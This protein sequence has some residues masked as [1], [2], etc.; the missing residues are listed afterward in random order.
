MGQD[1]GQGPAQ[2]PVR[3]RLPKPT[4]ASP[5]RPFSSSRDFPTPTSADGWLSLLKAPDVTG[6]RVALDKVGDRDKA[7]V[8]EALME[9]L[10][11][12]ERSLRDVAL[13]RLT[14]LEAGRKAL[15]RQLLETDSVDRAWSLARAQ[16][17]F[18]KTYPAAWREP[19]IEKAFE[20][21]EAKDRR[22]SRCSFCSRKPT[23]PRC[24]TAS[25]KKPWPIARRNPTRKLSTFLK[26]LG[27]DP[28]CAFP[29][30]LEL[31]ACGLKMSAKE[32][33]APD[34]AEDP[35]LEQFAGFCHHHGDELM[36]ALEKI[37]WLDPDDLYYL[38]FDLVER[39]GTHRKFGAEVL[40][41]VI[42]RAG[43]TKICAAGEEQ[44]Q[45]RWP[46][47]VQVRRG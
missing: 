43:R 47:V 1:A 34:R 21:H 38:G 30:R 27:R 10:Q 16:A 6:R 15:A 24:A 20:Y 22:A 46:G 18:V 26:L 7:D 40:H 32:L 14:R 31:A 28:A 11:H 2:T 4:S 8:A 23:P 19:V 36:P 42:K 35:C 25:K 39:G 13:A 5:P 9:Q 41:L 17:P 12:P 37:K 29:I 33:G 44:A 3:L 45:E